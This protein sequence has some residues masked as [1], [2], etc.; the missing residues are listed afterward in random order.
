VTGFEP[1][2]QEMPRLAMGRIGLAGDAHRLARRTL[3][4]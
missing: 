4:V 3:P 1:S 2:R